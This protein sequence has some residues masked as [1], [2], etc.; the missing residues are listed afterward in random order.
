[1]K[2]LRV[3]ALNGSPRANGNTARALRIVISEL[4]AVGIEAETVQVGGVTFA[5]CK[6]CGWCGENKILRCVQN[7]DPMN[8]IIPKMAA[9]DGIILASP[10]YFADL[11]PE[12][13]AVMDR[14]GF[15]T[16]M[17][18]GLLRR[19]AG[20]AVAVARRAGAVHAFDSMNHFFLINEM[21]I[22]GSSY[23][24]ILIGRDPGDV[25]SDD[26][27]RQTMKNLGINMGWLLKKIHQD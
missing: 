16:R 21:V 19:K 6:A 5:G 1:M 2:Q 20:A 26:E 15:V 27:G 3:L 12:I 18:G 23:W 10:V 24:N 25:E 14:G 13:K 8:Q 9:A 17:N 7:D 4:M 22:P 11:T